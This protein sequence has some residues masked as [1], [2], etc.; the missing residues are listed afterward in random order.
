MRKAL[1]FNGKYKK[2]G[3]V[4]HGGRREE[5]QLWEQVLDVWKKLC[6]K[7]CGDNGEKIPQ[8]A[9]REKKI[10]GRAESIFRKH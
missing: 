5:W 3:E 1:F 4:L 7:C 10:N 9:Q 6:W 2:E 8:K